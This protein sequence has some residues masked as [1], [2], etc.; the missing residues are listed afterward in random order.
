MN[1]GKKIRF[2]RIVF[3]DENIEIVYIFNDCVFDA[4]EILNVNGTTFHRALP[5]G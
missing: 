4:A 3:A 2:A 1:S 5:L